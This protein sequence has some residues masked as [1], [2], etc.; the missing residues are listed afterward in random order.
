MAS[1]SIEC[2]L[3]TP[4]AAANSLT[5]NVWWTLAGNVVYSAGQWALLSALAK[6]GS[7]AQV[8]ELALGLAVTGPL[9]VA[10]QLNL[11]GI[12]ATDATAEFSF[13]DYLGLRWICTSCAL[14]VTAAVA[15]V[16]AYAAGVVWVILLVGLM[17]AFDS[18]S[19]I[20]Y[21]ALLQH[22]R[23]TRIGKSMMAKGT[24]ALAALALAMALAHSVIAAA[25]ALALISGLMFAFYDR[26][27]VSFK[28]EHPSAVSVAPPKWNAKRF[29]A[30]FRLA[31]PL[32]LVMVLV[33]L[34]LNMPRYFVDRYRGEGELGAFA[35]LSYLIVAGN[36]V[37]NACGQAAA[38]RLAKLYA[39][40]VRR[41][42]W[43]LLLLLLGIAAACGGLSIAA[44]AGAG[45]RIITVLYTRSYA[46][47]APLLPGLMFAATLLYVSQFLGYGLTAARIFRAQVPLFCAVTAATAVACRLFIPTRGL[48][49]AVTA[50]GL[51]FIVQLLGSAGILIF[52]CLPFPAAAKEAV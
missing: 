6:M 31:W 33:S 20:Y 46:A 11:R 44:V 42:F 17:R 29:V 41:G 40:G 14:A 32:A 2:A 21:G 27:S 38:P 28:S 48:G 47:Y 5:A 8:G 1:V 39:F 45:E 9:F 10:S 52:Q 22:E 35:A 37:I 4:A 43:K 19:D 36:T 3:D 7:Q 49:G 15:I 13:G 51:G 34:N 16:S 24:L 12:Q 50:M 18:L 23:M 25:G 26:R 30:L